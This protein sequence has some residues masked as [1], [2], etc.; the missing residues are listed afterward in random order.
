MSKSWRR[1]KA[2][3]P[4]EEWDGSTAAFEE[5]SSYERRE[6]RQPGAPPSSLEIERL[7]EAAV[8]ERRARPGAGRA[9]PVRSAE[10]FGTATALH[11]IR[12]LEDLWAI[13]SCSPA[14]RE[15]EAL[16]DD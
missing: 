4:F 11:Q 3:P 9:V 5:R 10:T 16:G 7:I 2:E 6:R 13:W 1:G 15:P 14:P 8:R 12:T